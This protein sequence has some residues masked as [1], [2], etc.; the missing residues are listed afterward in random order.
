[1]EKL[2]EKL[3]KKLQERDGMNTLRQLNIRPN[4]TDFSSNDYLGFASSKSIA[5]RAYKLFRE[6]GEQMNGSRGSRLL[7]GNDRLYEDTEKSIAKFH[8]SPSSLI[9]NSGYT[10]NLGIISCIPQRG[11]II[12]YDE[13]VH[14]SIREGIL[15]CRAS[16]SKYAHNDLQDLEQKL[17]RITKDTGREC[18]VITESVFSMDGDSPNLKALV[19]LCKEHNCRLI[20]DE[21]HAIG[22]TQKGIVVSEELTKQVFARVVTFGKALGCHGAAVLGSE[23][24]KAYLLNYARSFIYSTALPPHSVATIKAAYEHLDS[25]IGLQSIRKLNSN[26]AILRSCT[27][28][29]KISACFLPSDS[30]VQA[31]LIPGNEKVKA[32]SER[33]FKEGFDVRPIMSPTVPPSKERLRICLHSFNTETEIEG[34]IKL[35]AEITL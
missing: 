17:E 34:L 3:L 1:M 7:M 8:S 29:Y 2:P 23:D 26:I 19:T 6:R 14:A 4:L 24:L 28:K 13:L 27:E 35:L 9:F 22:I 33:L 31:M 32:I 10:A 30:A 5:D 15:L 25:E 16:S 21:A 11:D 12:L 18:Y 20:I